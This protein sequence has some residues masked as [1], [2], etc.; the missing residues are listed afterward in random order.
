MRKDKLLAIQLR[1]KHKSYREI[2][3]ILGIP[4]STLATWFKYNTASAQTKLFLTNK[5][6]KVVAQ[7][8]KNFV[9]R[10]KKR[11]EEWRRG[12]RE[13]A[14]RDFLKL[15]RNPLF[16]AGIML[17]WAEG[18]SKEKNPI[19]LSNTD[20]RMINLYI[21]FLINELEILKERVRITLILYPDLSEKACIH[22]WSKATGIPKS[23]FYKTQFI[24]GRHPSKRLA[25]GICMVAC[26]TRR[27][28]EK[29]IV[30]IDL[31]SQKLIQ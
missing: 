2:H 25:H 16:V 4:K 22:F 11:W 15:A 12:A 1:R 28:K 6:N 19:R 10:N 29:I 9:E 7:R 31:L 14:K 27:L 21:K 26:N 13:E 3:E 20:P 17:Y 5:S 8:I 24:K 18:D 30:W 23:Q